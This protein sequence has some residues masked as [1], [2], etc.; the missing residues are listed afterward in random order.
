[1]ESYEVESS[2]TL[3]SELSKYI[4]TDGHITLASPGGHSEKWDV[5]K[6]KDG[7]L[8]F[9][10]NK[11]ADLIFS[12][13]ITRLANEGRVGL[14]LRSHTDNKDDSGHPVQELRGYEIWTEQHFGKSIITFRQIS[15]KELADACET[16]AQTGEKLSP[17]KTIIYCGK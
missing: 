13:R 6:K 7:G 8:F 14:I 10:Q 11:Y 1:M 3:I 4:Y 17:E 16:D 9:G 12:A 5:R 15:V 2:A